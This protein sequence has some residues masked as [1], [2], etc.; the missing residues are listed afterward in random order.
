MEK[1]KRIDIS[2]VDSATKMVL[3]INC[4]DE[5]RMRDC[6]YHFK[7][8]DHQVFFMYGGWGYNDARLIGSA[9]T[10][11]EARRLAA[12]WLERYV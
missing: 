7:W 2:E 6:P 9:L 10:L 4:M 5:Y 12:E 11:D 8:L 3:W 1:V